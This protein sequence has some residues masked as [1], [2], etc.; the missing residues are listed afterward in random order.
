MEKVYI[1]TDGSYSD[2]HIEAVFSSKDEAEEYKKW[3]RLLNYIEEYDVDSVKY[4]KIHR[5]SG[6]LTVFLE[7]NGEKY[8]FG[9]SKSCSGKNDTYIRESVDSICG[10]YYTLCIERYVSDNNFNQK[11]CEE[12][13]K[14]TAYDLMAYAKYLMAE[15]Y[16][17][18]K[19][20]EMLGK[21]TDE[22]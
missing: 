4:N 21:R 2:Y 17:E 3:H 19:I 20:N 9:W 10:K 16:D 8:T 22:E 6:L 18:D 1:V 12:K 11:L 15:G 13:F 14:K 5:Y 7:V